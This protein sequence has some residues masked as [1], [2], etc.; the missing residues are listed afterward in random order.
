MAI[1]EPLVVLNK[2]ITL[3]AQTIAAMVTKLEGIA[4]YSNADFVLNS[5]EQTMHNH[6]PEFF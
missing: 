3:S 2:V 4:P 1:M 6:D 5:S